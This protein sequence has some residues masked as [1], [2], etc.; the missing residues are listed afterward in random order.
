MGWIILSSE[1]SSQP[2][3][4]SPTVWKGQGLFFPRS[5]RPSIRCPGRAFLPEDPG[6]SLPRRAHEH[7]APRDH[8]ADRKGPFEQVAAICW[9]LPAWRK[10]IWLLF[11]EG[12]DQKRLPTLFVGA[13][14]LIIGLIVYHQDQPEEMAMIG[15]DVEKMVLTR[16]PRYH[17]GDRI[18]IHGRETVVFA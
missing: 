11:W 4:P 6:C 9:N 10:A 7:D 2:D 17:I 18:L 13:Q 3:S 15:R 5:A 1:A 14:T 8:Q 12:G 16:R